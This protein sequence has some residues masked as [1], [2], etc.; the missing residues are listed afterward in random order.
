VHRAILKLCYNHFNAEA[1]QK[2]KIVHP[3][4]LK[5]LSFLTFKEV[6]NLGI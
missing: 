4:I 6:K 2:L 1:C 3:N 5:G